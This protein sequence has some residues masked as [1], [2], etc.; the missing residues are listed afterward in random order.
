MKRWIK[1]KQEE[2]NKTIYDSTRD[3]RNVII[4]Q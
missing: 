3:I 1:K 2:V 4:I